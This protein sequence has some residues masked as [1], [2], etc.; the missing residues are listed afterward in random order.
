MAC[1]L[2]QLAPA[3]DLKVLARS[4]WPTRIVDDFLS[5]VV[6]QLGVTDSNC[7]ALDGRKPR[8][9]RGCEGYLIRPV[10]TRRLAEA[11][12]NAQKG[13]VLYTGS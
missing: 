7:A 5:G 8:I 10:T 9:E 6:S 12:F 2:G 11:F 13:F 4:T 1:G 3:L